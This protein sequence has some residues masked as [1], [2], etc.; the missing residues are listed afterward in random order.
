MAGE[1]TE[2]YSIKAS[3]DNSNVSGTFSDT[4]D[5]AGTAMFQGPV[6]ATTSWVQLPVPAA[7]SGACFIALRNNDATNYIQ[8][9][10][11]S[12]GSNIFA[13]ANAGEMVKCSRIPALPYIRANTA[14]C[15]CF[16]VAFQ[17]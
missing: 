3:K 14:S 9:A 6:T 11:D 2:N 15:A 8:L 17:Q 7:L 13:R 10:V 5:M 1:I 16:V 4:I 12:G